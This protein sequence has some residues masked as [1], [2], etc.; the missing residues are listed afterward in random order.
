M[1]TDEEIQSVYSEFLD[2][3]GSAMEFARR[4]ERAVLAKAMQKQEPVAYLP[5]LSNRA[6][7]VDGHYAIGRYNPSG[8]YEYWNL[9]SHKWSSCSDDVLTIEQAT[10]LLHKVEIPTNPQPAQAAAI[11]EGWK[12][13]PIEPTKEM[14]DA[15]CE[16]SIAP[17]GNLSRYGY[18]AMLSASPK[19]E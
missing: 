9:R 15:Y 16:H 11:P 8:Y 7:G 17:I 10:E 2:M 13:V 1:L 12:L 14:C 5:F 6:D 4:I 18:K 3:K 19:P